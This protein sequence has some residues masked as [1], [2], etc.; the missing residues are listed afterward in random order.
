MSVHDIQI[1]RLGYDLKAYV[2]IQDDYYGTIRSGLRTI[3]LDGNKYY[4][5]A[6]GHRVDVTRKREEF[7]VREQ[8]TNSAV[9][10][11]KKWQ[12]EYGR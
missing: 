8:Y 1:A 11:Y 5:N 3:F 9:E 6:D 4:I 7:L 2:E 10:H 12:R